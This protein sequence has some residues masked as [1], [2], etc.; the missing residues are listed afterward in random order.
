MRS[1]FRKLILNLQEYRTLDSAGDIYPEYF[2]RFYGKWIKA[3][4]FHTVTLLFY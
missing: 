4:Y 3:I 1:Y 2:M